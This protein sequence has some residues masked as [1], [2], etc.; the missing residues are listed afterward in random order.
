[1]SK[2]NIIKISIIIL[3]MLLI[4]LLPT[5]KPRTTTFEEIVFDKIDNKGIATLSF[6][7]FRYNIENTNKY[8]PENKITK[9]KDKI[10]NLISY[11][12]TFSLQE[13]KN[14]DSDN[15]TDDTKLVILFDFIDN[16]SIQITTKDYQNLQITLE[17]SNNKVIRKNY[18]I[19]NNKLDQYYLEDVFDSI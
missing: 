19:L 16:H 1:M 6:Y 7:I 15:K 8:S 10:N 5:F 14:T 2:K 12:N 4:F 9:E 11:L 13:R 3:A 18:Q 17:L